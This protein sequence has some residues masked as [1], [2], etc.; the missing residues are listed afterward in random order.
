MTITIKNINISKELITKIET[1]DIPHTKDFVN[2]FL[3]YNYMCHNKPK[4]WADK[5]LIGSVKGVSKGG[6][7][8]LELNSTKG[9]NY[10]S[11]KKYKIH[12]GKRPK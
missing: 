4:V 10:I 5:K 7:I 6:S 11:N 3:V 1:F 12:I 8:S 2:N 9:I